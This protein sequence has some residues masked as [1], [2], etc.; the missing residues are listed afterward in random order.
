VLFRSPRENLSTVQ[1]AAGRTSVLGSNGPW[2]T[3]FH[4]N[5]QCLY[6]T[7]E[8]P[9]DTIG[10]DDLTEDAGWLGCETLEIVQHPQ[11]Q[12]ITML[13][14][15][16]AEIEG[17]TFNGSAHTISYDGSQTTYVLRGQNGHDARLWRQLRPGAERTQSTSNTIQFNPTTHQVKGDQIRDIDAA[18]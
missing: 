5:V 15:Q 2:T 11:T 3:V 9:G 18:N 14:T 6:G 17:K 16:N 12:H 1:P 13:G 10:R 7:V 4:D 8:Q